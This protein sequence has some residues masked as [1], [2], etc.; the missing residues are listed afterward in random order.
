MCELAEHTSIV[1]IGKD[2]NLLSDIVAIFV[3]FMLN[4]VLYMEK[5][6][7]IK[8]ELLVL[9]RENFAEDRILVHRSDPE[10]QVESFLRFGDLFDICS[11]NLKE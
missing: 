4:L 10:I 5:R 7:V 11:V 1:I 3:N 6:F 8:L 9:F 2:I